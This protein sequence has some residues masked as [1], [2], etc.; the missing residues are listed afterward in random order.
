MTI[1]LCLHSYFFVSSTIPEREWIRQM[2]QPSSPRK[3]RRQRKVTWRSRSTPNM[4]PPNQ[5]A[6]LFVLNPKDNTLIHVVHKQQQIKKETEISVDWTT[7]VVLPDCVDIRNTDLGEKAPDTALKIGVLAQAKTDLMTATNRLPQLASVYW[8]LHLV[9]LIEGNVEQAL[10]HLERYLK[11]TLSVRSIQT[12]KRQRQLEV[13]Y[14]F[15]VKIHELLKDPQS[16]LLAWRELILLNPKQYNY[17]RQRALLLLKLNQPTDAFSDLEKAVSLNPADKEARFE[18]ALYY[19]KNRN[20]GF[21]SNYFQQFNE[22]WPDDSHARAYLG[23]TWMHLRR[24][25]EALAEL[26][27]SLYFNP[28]NLEAIQTT[29]T[30]WKVYLC[31]A[32]AYHALGKVSE[33]SR[34]D[35]E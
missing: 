5:P 19:F 24:Y 20:W 21:A 25:A 2:W 4:P 12:N 16:E 32:E 27:A 31:R 15:K 17:Y 6:D 9:S 26:T 35:V 13:A 29:F 14:L 34:A 33:S 11:C 30:G 18:H 23:L 10:N 28:L 22:R 7:P 3:H 1:S 8:Q